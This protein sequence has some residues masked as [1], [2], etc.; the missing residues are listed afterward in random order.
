MEQCGKQLLIVF[1][2]TPAGQVLCK[3]DMAAPSLYVFCYSIDSANYIALFGH[4]NLDD[5][6]ELRF[7]GIHQ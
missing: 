6:Q 4:Q 2:C 5:D 1:P 3:Q 7:V